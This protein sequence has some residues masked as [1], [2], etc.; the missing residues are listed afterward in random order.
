MPK[1]PAFLNAMEAIMTN[2]VYGF[3]TEPEDWE[4]ESA[5]WFEPCPKCIVPA[6]VWRYEVA[7]GS[8]NIYRGLCCS[9][10]SHFEGELPS[11]P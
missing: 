10:R 6:F 7:E 1:A 11:D 5:T 9:D 8:I 2:F 3:T 4:L